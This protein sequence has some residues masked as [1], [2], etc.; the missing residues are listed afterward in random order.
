MK[1][2]RNSLWNCSCPART[3]ASSNSFGSNT[4]FQ[5]AWEDAD[6]SWLD[7]QAQTKARSTLEACVSSYPM[8]FKTQSLGPRRRPAI[9]MNG[10]GILWRQSQPRRLGGCPWVVLWLARFECHRNSQ[11]Q[12][13]TDDEDEQPPAVPSSHSGL[14]LELPTPT[15]R[16]AGSV[17]HAQCPVEAMTAGDAVR[18]APSQ[19]VVYEDADV[20]LN[21]LQTSP[22]D[23][24]KP[25]WLENEDSPGDPVHGPQE[26]ETFP[27]D[28]LNSL[29]EA[30]ADRE[31]QPR[32]SWLHCTQFTGM[33]ESPL[34]RCK[35]VTAD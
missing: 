16:V 14:S 29:V 18:A 4:C 17:S 20:G 7:G 28:I 22:S 23:A 26:N 6:K 3:T 15:S 21:P 35:C 13:V 1:L 12:P 32:A 9:R 19:T 30:Q 31:E 27:A 25:G 11:D 24:T 8:C 34:N 10:T 5:E 33:M 2:R